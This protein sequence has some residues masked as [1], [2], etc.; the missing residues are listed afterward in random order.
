VSTEDDSVHFLAGK[1]TPSAQ[2]MEL[3]SGI[4]GQQ[5]WEELSPIFFTA[6]HS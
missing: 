4:M 5:M 2:P 1:L 3:G 6:Q